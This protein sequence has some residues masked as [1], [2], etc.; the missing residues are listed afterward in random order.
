MNLRLD[1]ELLIRKI[2]D[3][4]EEA[5]ENGLAREVVGELY[6]RH[7]GFVYNVARKIL[8]DTNDAQEIRQDVFLKLYSGKL[9]K[10]SSAQGGIFRNWLFLVTRN[11]SF[12]YLQRERKVFAKSVDIEEFGESLEQ[13]SFPSAESRMETE[14]EVNLIKNTIK[15]LPEE[16]IGSILFLANNEIEYGKKLEYRNIAE[17]FEIPVGTVKS[18][19]HRGRNLLKIALEETL[20]V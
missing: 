2:T 18:R 3:N 12:N 5:K 17:F 13:T 11:L 8:K 16:F 1:D 10:F 6:I 14:Q 4:W 15:K 9:Q 20:S 7:G 19:L